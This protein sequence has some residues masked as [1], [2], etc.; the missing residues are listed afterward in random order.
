MKVDIIR[1]IEIVPKR[2]AFKARSYNNAE[3]K[4]WVDFGSVRKDFS[5]YAFGVIPLDCNSFLNILFI[6]V[7]KLVSPSLA[8]SSS[9]CCRN[10]SVNRIWYCGDLFSFGVDMVLTLYY[11]NYMVTTIIMVTTKKTIPRSAGTL[12]RDLTTITLNEV[13]I[14]ANRYDSVHLCARQSKIYKSSKKHLHNLNHL[15]YIDNALAKSKDRIG[16]LNSYLATHDA[17]SVFFCVNACAHLF[18]NISSMVAL[19]GQPKGWLGHRVTSS[20]NPANVTAKEI[21]TSCG[22]YVNNYSEAVTMTTIPTP[23][24]SNQKL[25]KFYYLSTAQVVQT[26]ATTE[27]QARKSLGK[28]SLIFIA[29]IRLYP[30]VKN[31]INFG[32]V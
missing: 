31:S 24:I 12:P 29:R 13:M 11:Y 2:H 30:M 19:V 17:Q 10:S 16:T 21:G 14:M 3:L 1:C 8:A 22:D 9:S 28:S 6:H 5:N 15:G 4:N 26:T 32:R 23:V 25:F 7:A 27:C 18:I 20:S